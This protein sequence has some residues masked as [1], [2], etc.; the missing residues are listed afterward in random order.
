LHWIY[1]P[2]AREPDSHTRC[3]T[4]ARTRPDTEIRA[5]RVPYCRGLADVQRADKQAGTRPPQANP[6]EYPDLT[7]GYTLAGVTLPNTTPPLYDPYAKK[8]GS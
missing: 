6:G 1:P 3:W 2:P 5:C 8:V 4:C 7:Y